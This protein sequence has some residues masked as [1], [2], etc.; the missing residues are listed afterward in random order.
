MVRGLVFGFLTACISLAWVGG[1]PAIAAGRSDIPHYRIALDVDYPGG[2]YSARQTVTVANS[3]NLAWDEVVFSVTAASL[4]SFRLTESAVDGTPA[5]ATIAG[6]VLRVPLTPPAAPGRTITV[7][8]AYEVGVPRGVGRFGNGS[9][10]LALGS[11]YPVLN[12]YRQG[13]LTFDGAAPGWTAHRYTDVGDAFFTD[14][15]DYD[16]TVQLNRAATVAAT[17]SLIEQS[18]NTWR[19][20]AGRVREFAL[21]ISDRFRVESIRVGDTVVASYYLPNRAAAG[22]KYLH[23]AAASMAWFNQVLG[24]YPYPQLSIVQMAGDTVENVGQEYPGLILMSDAVVP[25]TNDFADYL[26]YLLA[27][28]IAHQWFY[29]IVGSDQLSQPWVDEALVTWIGRHWQSRIAGA[30]AGNAVVRPTRAI[31]AGIYEFG[32]N[33]PYFSI[34]YRE[35]ASMIEEVYRTLGDAAFFW[36]L[37]EYVATYRDR[38]ATP[39]GLL[40]LLQSY[41]SENLNSIYARYLRNPHYQSGPPLRADIWLPDAWEDGASLVI[42]STEPLARVTIYV[43]QRPIWSGPPEIDLWIDA[44]S[45]APGDHLVTVALEAPDG[46]W[47]ERARRVVILDPARAQARRTTVAARPVNRYGA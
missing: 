44:G 11:F 45:L 7:E 14:S 18:G 35:G 41:T 29:G 22:Q 36:A 39:A 37:G 42:T 43:D 40:D 26:S 33:S 8:L 25:Q 13:P 9:S 47:V 15:A 34:V 10:I 16:V 17:G 38:I 24:D 30:G 32:G 21:A 6:S 2:R 28:E 27:H 19:F 31:D 3:T 1:R 46:R 20:Q 23:V 5:A 4:G 12:V